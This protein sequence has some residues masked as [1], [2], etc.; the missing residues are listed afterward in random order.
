VAND[1][2][3]A[4]LKAQAGDRPVWLAALTHPGEDEIA[5]AALDRLRRTFPD[6]LLVLVP[7]HPV[8]ADEITEL[9]R[10]RHLGVARRSLGE[11]ISPSIDVYLGDTL[12]EMGL[13]YKLAPVTFLG[14]SFND[15]GGHNPVEAALCGSALVTGPRVSNARAV[16]KE[17]WINKGAV[18]VETADALCDQLH[19]LLSEPEK[20]RR[21]AARARTLVDAG[22]GALDKSLEYL[23]PYLGAKSLE[24][25]SEAERE[26]GA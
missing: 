13:Y 21:Q 11:A 22:R 12:G 20:A 2:E 17:F 1:A 8:R 14:G 23:E 16:Y 5:L 19:Q 9:V 18:R 25:T 4:R 3:L 15:A 6:L 26:D 24:V 7:R 10:A